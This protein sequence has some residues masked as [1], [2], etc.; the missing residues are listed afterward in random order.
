MIPNKSFVYAQSRGHNREESSR[1]VRAAVPG[2]TTRH[3]QKRLATRVIGSRCK[4]EIHVPAA[5]QLTP[6]PLAICCLQEAG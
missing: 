6:R 1:R 5:K 2:P 4:R 3:P